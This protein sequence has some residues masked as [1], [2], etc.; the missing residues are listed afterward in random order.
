VANLLRLLASEPVLVAGDSDNDT[1]MLTSFPDT[2][3]RLIVNRRQG[4]KIA[5]LLRLAARGE[6]GFL[7]QEIDPRRGEFRSGVRRG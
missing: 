2:R 4:G 1:A 5:R 3:L 7:A 6:R